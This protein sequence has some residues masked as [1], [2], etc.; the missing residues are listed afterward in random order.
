MSFQYK[1]RLSRLTLIFLIQIP[2]CN[3]SPAL[4]VG[5][6]LP[7]N[8]NHCVDF[9]VLFCR[10]HRERS[11]SLSHLHFA[12]LIAFPEYF[13]P[14]SVSSNRKHSQ[15]SLR[16]TKRVYLFRMQQGI[17]QVVLRMK[18]RDLRLYSLKN[19]VSMLQILFVCVSSVS[20]FMGLFL[21]LSKPLSVQ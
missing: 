17:I 18:G 7:S 4:Q 21:W 6:Y 8:N 12:L 15:T 14:L 5:G 13:Q 2:L 16:L 19:E 9:P 10:P 1:F 20:L 11:Q 3:V